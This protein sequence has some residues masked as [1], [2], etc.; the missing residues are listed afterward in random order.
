MLFSEIKSSPVT[1][2]NNVGRGWEKGGVMTQTLYAHMNKR[3]KKKR[4]NVAIQQISYE[5]KLN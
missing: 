4:N 3:N 1:L 5:R 2:R